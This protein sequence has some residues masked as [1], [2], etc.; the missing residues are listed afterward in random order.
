[1]YNKDTDIEALVPA[2]VSHHCLV[3]SSLSYPL[4]RDLKN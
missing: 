3:V 4:N 1:V 2:S